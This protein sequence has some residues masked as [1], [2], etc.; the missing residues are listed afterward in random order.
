VLATNPKV[1]QRIQF[2][3]TARQGLLVS[4]IAKT[5][6]VNI[7]KARSW[8]HRYRYPFTDARTLR[9]GRSLTEEECSRRR[10]ILQQ[11]AH[12]KMTL[13]EVGEILKMTREGVR[14]LY[15]YFNIPREKQRGGPR[16]AGLGVSVEKLREDVKS[17]RFSQEKLASLNGVSVPT[18]LK[19]CR[20]HDI[21]FPG[22]IHR[23]AE[24]FALLA[25]GQA[26]CRRCK[27][28]KAIGEF[29]RNKYTITGLNKECIKCNAERHA[30]R[31]QK[32]SRRR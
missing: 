22:K 13:T 31:K 28:P 26:Y 25:E 5:L 3:E 27:I 32:K 16:E 18:L 8:C 11:A 20:K 30:A 1:I 10:I 9:S 24:A 6:R 7:G 4:E 29:S 15:I 23:R 2:F 19:L 12:E 14:K 21:P 17:K